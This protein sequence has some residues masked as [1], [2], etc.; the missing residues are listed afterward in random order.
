MIHSLHNEKRIWR[1]AG[2]M[3][4]HNDPIRPVAQEGA[5]ANEVLVDREHFTA[6][7]RKLIAT[8]PMPKAAI[9]KRPKM[10]R[11]KSRSKAKPSPA[12]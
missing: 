9:P 8:P 12:E 1:Y 3:K 4:A 10:V 11:P 2:R 6:V 5:V 7:V